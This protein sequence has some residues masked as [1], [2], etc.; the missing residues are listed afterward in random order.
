VYHTNR[1]WLIKLPFSTAEGAYGPVALEYTATDSASNRSPTVTVLVYITDASP[2]AEPERECH[3]SGC[4]VSCICFPGLPGPALLSP[5]AVYVPHVDIWFPSIQVIGEPPLHIRVLSAFSGVVVVETTVQVGA[6]Y[7]D[8]GARAV[9]NIDGDISSRVSRYGLKAVQ[10]RSP[11]PP[12]QP[13]IIKYNVADVAGNRAETR[14]RRVF[15][16]CPSTQRLCK[17]EEDTNGWYCSVAMDACILPQP[18]PAVPM[19]P[20]TRISLRGPAEV[21]LPL[22]AAYPSCS[23]SVPLEVACDAGA[24]AFDDIDGDLSQ[25]VV[26]CKSGYSFVDF[27]IQACMLDVD[28]AGRHDLEFWITDSATGGRV[29]VT[30]T[31][32]VVVP[33]AIGE[34][35]CLDRSCSFNGVCTPSQ[36]Q[37]TKALSNVAPSL[38]L[39]PVL[40]QASAEEVLVPHG[41]MY[42]ACNA[43]SSRTSATPCEPG[44]GTLTPA[45][46]SQRQ[47]IECAPS[48]MVHC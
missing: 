45:G 48:K 12:S 8:A 3:S 10:T 32:W 29:S 11:T 17:Y 22:H 27:G 37:P 43:T 6:A 24:Q 5:E 34:E 23:S 31:I 4:S 18:V 7:N 25:L 33:C 40:G 26:A 41:W 36:G 46:K 35:R 1:A 13:Y 39:R 30:R 19:P 28:T 16:Q 47:C 2:C 20:A 44:A 9:D 38:A 14:T 42:A 15:V 21:E